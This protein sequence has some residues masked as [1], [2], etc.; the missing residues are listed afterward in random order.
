MIGKDF[1]ELI[2]SWFCFHKIRKN[3][4]DWQRI[5]RVDKRIL[6]LIR[7]IRLIRLIKGS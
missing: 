2:R 6:R 7:A 4:K 1:I 3:I 5:H